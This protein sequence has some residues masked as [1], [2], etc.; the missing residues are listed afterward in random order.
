MIRLMH[1]DTRRSYLDNRDNYQE[2]I[3]NG[4]EKDLFLLI[5]NKF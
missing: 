3:I 5:S 2:I 1:C 4:F